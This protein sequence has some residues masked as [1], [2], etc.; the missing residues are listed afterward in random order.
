MSKRSSSFAWLSQDLA[1]RGVE[2]V[3]V[4]GLGNQ[5][6]QYAVGRALATRLGLPLVLDISK[7]FL[8]P[9]YGYDLVH[10]ALGDQR[11]RDLP[12]RAW[13]ARDRALRVADAVRLPWM[14]YVT[15]P[16]PPALIDLSR[17]RGPSCLNGYWQSYDYF[18]AVEPRLRE[19]L[20]F[21]TPPDAKT[22]A[23]MEAIASSNAVALHVRR[24]D[25]A[26]N[27]DTNAFHGLCGKPYYDAALE[28]VLDKVGPSPSLFVVSDDAAWCRD[29]IRY[30]LPTT[31]VDWNDKATSYNDMRLLS[32]CRGLVIANS[33]FS[34][35]ASFLNAHRD[36]VVVAPRRWFANG[37][38][39]DLPNAPWLTTI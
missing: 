26:E 17:V 33:S 15:E 27:P 1:P 37:L 6:F 11:V 5:L 24:G 14:R 10:F 22:A 39:S 3:M 21:V 9:P 4:S 8:D 18:S 32:L 20:R 2:M 38:I 25:Y 16:W 12:Y 34:W 7:L 23:C 13:R 36:K 31:Y 29:N 19:E 35:W 28:I 30:P